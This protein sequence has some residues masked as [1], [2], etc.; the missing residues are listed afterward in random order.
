MS[1]GNEN[2]NQQIQQQIQINDHKAV[3]TY[4]N[5]CRVTGT[6][7]EL[8]IDFGLNK[9][10][11]GSVTDPIDIDHRIVLN[12]YTAKRLWAALGMSVQRYEQAFGMLETDFN[13]RVLP[14]ARQ[15][16]QS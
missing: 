13:K 7:E 16:A 3:A 10:P 9:K 1:T 11:M 6:P 2:E 12:F 15:Q 14:S 5:F 8:I 4:S